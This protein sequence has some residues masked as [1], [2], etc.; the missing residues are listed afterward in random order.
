MFRCCVQCNA[1]EFA[2]YFSN[3]ALDQ[4]GWQSGGASMP[5][6]A[7]VLD[8]TLWLVLH[9]D[10]WQILRKWLAAWRRETSR[11]LE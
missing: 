10:R 8:L 9:T 5:L 1:I 6:G 3:A 11:G 7:I 4:I 2:R